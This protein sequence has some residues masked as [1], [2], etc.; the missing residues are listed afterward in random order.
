MHHLLYVLP[1]LALILFGLLPFRQALLL[2]A[3]ILAAAAII[4]SLAWKN[5]RRP[6]TLGVEDM[7]GG[8]A[9]VI[10]KEAEAVKV[11]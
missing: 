4:C 1:L 6:V 11:L 3:P 8:V 10:D 5:R 7:I 2:Y 9:E